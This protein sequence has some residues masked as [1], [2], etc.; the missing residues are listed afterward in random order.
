M[1]EPRVGQPLRATVSDPDGGVGS[2]EWKW[3]RRE[4]GGDWTPIPGATSNTYI[5][6]R[7]DSGNDLRVVAIY[8]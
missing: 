5:P 1:S 8:T 6:T 7:D 2:I 4:S 3:E